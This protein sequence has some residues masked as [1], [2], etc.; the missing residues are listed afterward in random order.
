MLQMNGDKLPEG[1]EVF[2][3]IIETPEKMFQF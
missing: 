3:E 2:K 1:R